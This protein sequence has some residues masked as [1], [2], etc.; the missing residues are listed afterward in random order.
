MAVYDLPSLINSVIY[1][2]MPGSSFTLK[3]S[4]NS[5]WTL[6]SVPLAFRLDFVT[7]PKNFLSQIMQL[8]RGLRGVHINKA[9]RI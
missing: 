4:D 3:G 9:C 5:G 6:T 2:R 1:T 8:R 7:R